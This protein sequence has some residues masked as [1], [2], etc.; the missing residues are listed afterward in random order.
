LVQKWKQLH[1]KDDGLAV[2]AK[3]N[4]QKDFEQQHEK[5]YKYF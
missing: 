3:L 1:Y 2:A 4:N 5:K